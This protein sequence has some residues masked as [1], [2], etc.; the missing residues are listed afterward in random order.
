MLR[1]PGA[2]VSEGMPYDP[3]WV[4]DLPSVPYSGHLGTAYASWATDFPE[5]RV[6][7]IPTLVIASNIDPIAPPE[8]TRLPSLDWPARSWHR[9]GM[10]GVAEQDLTHA[11]LLTHPRT[12]RMVARFLVDP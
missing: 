10:L 4:G 8:V 6:P 3:S 2:V 11:Q 5:Y 1:D 9:A 7:A 12:A